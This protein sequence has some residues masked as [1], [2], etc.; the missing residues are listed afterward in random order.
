[1]ATLELYLKG[2]LFQTHSFWWPEFECQHWEDRSRIREFI[3]QQQIT[4]MTVAYIRQILKCNYQV[5]F[6]LVVKSE[7]E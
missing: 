1:M 5:S 2:K 4:W 3:L 6:M 7:K